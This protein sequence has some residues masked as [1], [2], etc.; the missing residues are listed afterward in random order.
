MPYF[1]SGSLKNLAAL[2]YRGVFARTEAGNAEA[3]ESV[4]TAEHERIV[5]RDNGV[6]Y[7]IVLCEFRD[8]V[9]ICSAYVDTFG[10]CGDAAVSGQGV[11][12]LTSLFSLSFFITACSLPPEPTT[13]MFIFSPPSM[14]EQAHAGECHDH[15]VFVAA[16]YHKVVADGAAGLCD[17]FYS[18]ALC[19][20]DIVAE[21]EERVRA[22]RYA[23]N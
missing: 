23:V 22:E 3:F 18:A 6:V 21:R 19:S 20:F 16:L 2:D 15:A 12:F 1:S 7:L 17:I 13:R 14:V 4:D 5:R 8:A 9:N 10:V 11:Y